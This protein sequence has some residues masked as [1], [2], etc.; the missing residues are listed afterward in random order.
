MKPI[1][2]AK[3]FRFLFS[4]NFILLW[5]GQAVSTLGDFV[6]DTTLVLWVAAILTH[7]QVWSPLAVSGVLFAAAIPSL[8]FGP[9][10]GVFVDRWDKRG[11]LLWMDALRT[12]LIVILVLIVS[13]AFFLHSKLSLI[14]ELAATYVVVFLTSLCTQIFAP[15]RFALS[16]D[17]V[18]EYYRA[19]S[20]AVT[21][22]TANI[23][24]ILGPPLAAPLLFAVGVQW[25]LLINAL[26]YAVSFVTLLFV[27][28]PV[29]NVEA[30]T[31]NTQNNL[32]GEFK[33]GL[34]F[35]VKQSVLRTVML[36][37][38]ILIFGGGVG[39]TLSFFFATQNLHAS[40]YQYG[41]LSS[42]TGA[43]LLVGALFAFWGVQ[44]TGIA[45]AFWLGIV[46][47]S[48]MEIVY[49]RLTNFSVALVFLFLQGIPNAAIN[50]A[51][52]PLI[53][54]ATPHEFLGRVFALF[55]PITNLATLLSTLLTGYLA[56]T[57]LRTLHT[58]ILGMT[59]G[60]VDTMI[61]CAAL[62]T[63][64]GGLYAMYELGGER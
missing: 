6:F 37:M 32:T 23:A 25:A 45:R 14:G 2:F 60:T 48:V 28:L 27:R 18:E 31:G 34:L 21:Q 50:I 4:R 10:I 58:T 3:T 20:S 54:R 12:V 15:A 29:Q 22:A 26:S 19:R 46:V 7:G 17:I 53:M 47:I 38:F 39:S 30:K 55:M 43:G 51:V 56:S 44:K 52:G 40:S 9:I 35:L 61:M 63:L 16:V 41:I 33:T 8:L 64:M 13:P 11:V 59:F 5:F 42:A 62:L 49:A 1:S 36:T 24:L 57:L